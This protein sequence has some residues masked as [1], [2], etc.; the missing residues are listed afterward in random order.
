MKKGR[1]NNSRSFIN[2]MLGIHKSSQTELQFSKTEN[3]GS[4]S[5]NSRSPTNAKVMIKNKW[6]S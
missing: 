4:F 6:K 1:L 5:E 3:S 2:K